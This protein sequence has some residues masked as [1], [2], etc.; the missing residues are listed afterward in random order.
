MMITVLGCGTSTGVPLIGCAC[1]TCK[2]RDKKDKRLR[3]SIWVNWDGV[4]LLVDTSSDFRQQALT[5][6]IQH[7]DAVLYTHPHADHVSGI[8][9]LRC[10]NFLQKSNIPVYSNEWTCTE[11]PKRFPYIF[12]KDYVVEGGGI[13]QLE[14]NL[15]TGPFEVKGKQII[16]LP[17]RHGS[18]MALGFRF[19]KSAYITDCSVIPPATLDL[20]S[21][22]DTLILDCVRERPHPTHFNVDQALETVKFLK[23]RRTFLTHLGHDFKY[24]AWTKKLPKGVR[25]AHDGLRVSGP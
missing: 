10:Y 7:I 22:L 18:Q 23:P 4:S 15:V 21:G 1:S 20:L 5:H 13:P 8:D 6:K 3:A 9:E 16:P 17:V 19:G 12:E 2:S 11:L 14:L 25:L 24:S